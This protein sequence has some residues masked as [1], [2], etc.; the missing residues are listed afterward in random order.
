PAS[1]VVVTG[2]EPLEHP[3]FTPLIAAVKSAGRRVEV[4]SA[5]T[6][7]APDV[8][9]D[10][11]NVSLKIAHSGVPESRRLRPDAVTRLRDIGAW[12]KFVVGTEDDLGEVLALEARFAIPSARV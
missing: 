2:G 3:A 11:W 1:N 4:E 5:G 9:V 8:A 12:F 7:L 6:E 10:Q